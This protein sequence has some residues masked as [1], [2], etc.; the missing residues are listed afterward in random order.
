MSSSEDSM[1]SLSSNADNMVDKKL[2]RNISAFKIMTVTRGYTEEADKLLNYLV[3]VFVLYSRF[4]LN[5]SMQEYGIFDALKK[6]YL[7]SFIFAIY[8]VRALSS[9]L[10]ESLTIVPSSSG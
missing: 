10:M 6:Q 2:R 1:P 3:G 7:R 4:C 5:L 9:I 8:L